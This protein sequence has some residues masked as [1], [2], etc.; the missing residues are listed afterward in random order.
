M[1][2]EIEKIEAP[3]TIWEILVNQNRVRILRYFAANCEKAVALSILNQELKQKYNTTRIQAGI[4]ERNGYLNIQKS[5]RITIIQATPKLKKLA[6]V[7]LSWE[8]TTTR[9]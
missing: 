2:I 7:L 6:A 4:L 3:T 9:N 8:N 1:K 5:G